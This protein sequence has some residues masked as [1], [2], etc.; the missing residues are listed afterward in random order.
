MMDVCHG[1]SFWVFLPLHL[2]T[3]PYPHLHL[4][5]FLQHF[6]TFPKVLTLFLKPDF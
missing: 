4:F 3:Q 2:F 1:L 6:V 5:L